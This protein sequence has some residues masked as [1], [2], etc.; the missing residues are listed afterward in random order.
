MT[1]YPY[2]I[3]E[4][5]WGQFEMIIR[6]TLREPFESF[7]IEFTHTLKFH[8]SKS[9]KQPYTYQSYDEIVL[10]NVPKSMLLAHQAS[11]RDN[12][13]PVLVDIESFKEETH[14]L[15]R[16]LNNDRAVD[17]STHTD[18]LINANDYIAEEIRLAKE[19]LH[20]LE[21]RLQESNVELVRT[22]SLS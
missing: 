19:K 9:S 8:P 11:I 7:P 20:E 13:P 17:L 2:V 1:R 12:C 18:L 10:Y 14:E 16:H 3:E 4:S 15:I 6:I 5:G 22:P 21:A